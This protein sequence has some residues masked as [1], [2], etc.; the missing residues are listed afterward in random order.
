MVGPFGV[1][2]YF[3]GDSHRS[4]SQLRMINGISAVRHLF[5]SVAIIVA[6]R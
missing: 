4:L 6:Y 1:S 5:R 2:V 3:E